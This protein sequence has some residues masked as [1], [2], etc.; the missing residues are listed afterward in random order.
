MRRGCA[1]RA[2]ALRRA[3]A[4]TSAEAARLADAGAEAVNL[5]RDRRVSRAANQEDHQRRLARGIST[6]GDSDALHTG[7]LH[8]FLHMFRM[9][10]ATAG[11]FRVRQG[12]YHRRGRGR[13]FESGA[14]RGGK[15]AGAG[16]QFALDD[17]SA[18]A[19]HLH[20]EV[21]V[22]LALS[23]KKENGRLTRMVEARADA[24]RL[25][26]GMSHQLG[27]MEVADGGSA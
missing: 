27:R 18:D 17:A 26:P 5:L 14:V 19:V 8:E 25:D 20:R 21:R 1:Q 15:N 16:K 23:D 6:G 9:N 13:L 22:W 24:E 12:G 3:V 4:E 10:H 7:L 2:R 11:H